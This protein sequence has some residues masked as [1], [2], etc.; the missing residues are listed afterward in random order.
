[1]K[2]F[3][4]SITRS[5]SKEN[6][7]VI[8]REIRLPDGIEVREDYAAVYISIVLDNRTHSEMVTVYKNN[9]TSRPRPAQISWC[10]C[11]S[12]SRDFVSKLIKAM[13]VA[14]AIAYD[15]DRIK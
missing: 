14:Q 8:G 4:P 10:S 12:Q 1:M 9:L 6:D 5:L 2:T 3:T 11:G 13:Q 15:I 7:I